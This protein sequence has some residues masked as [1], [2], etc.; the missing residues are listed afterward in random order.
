[1]QFHH[2]VVHRKTNCLRP[3]PAS[4][5]HASPI[6]RAYQME[7]KPVESTRV[8][9]TRGIRRLGSAGRG[10]DG[11]VSACESRLRVGRGSKGAQMIRETAELFFD[12]CESGKGW[13]ACQAYCHEGA[14]FSAQA[15][16]LQGVDTLQA[17]TEWMKG[18]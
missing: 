15:G 7:Y 9:T 12:A 11:L 6:S 8:G 4:W 3:M 16:A 1:M 17:Y 14:T 2:P 18:L 13:D 5:P 10:V